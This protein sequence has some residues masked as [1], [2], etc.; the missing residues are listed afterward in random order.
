MAL[1]PMKR[2]CSIWLVAGLAALALA[3]SLRPAHAAPVETPLWQRLLHHGYSDSGPWITVHDQARVSYAQRYVSTGTTTPQLI[4]NFDPDGAPI[5]SLAACSFCYVEAAM[6]DGGMW[7]SEWRSRVGLQDF[8]RWFFRRYTAQGEQLAEVEVAPQVRLWARVLR[9]VN[10]VLEVLFLPQEQHGPVMLLRIDAEGKPEPLRTLA[11]STLWPDAW[12]EAYRR[13]EDG[14]LSLLISHSS[15]CPPIQLCNHRYFAVVWLDAQRE[16]LASY[17]STALSDTVELGRHLDEQGRLWRLWR[18]GASAINLLFVDS[19]GVPSPLRTLDARIPMASAS[20]EPF[21]GAIGGHALLRADDQLWLF[22]IKGQLS[23]HSPSP[24]G[25]ISFFRDES[26][27][28]HGYLLK[29]SVP[30]APLSLATLFD[31]RTLAPIAHF[32]RYRSPGEPNPAYRFPGSWSVLPDG[33]I[34]VGSHDSNGS[35]LAV[36]AIPGTPA[37]RPFGSGF[38]STP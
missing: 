7:V 31:P 14:R 11:F 25:P 6:S 38:E 32:D 15:I 37:Y 34:H 26:I 29:S 17:V 30:E 19:D 35:H 18:S 8:D 36:F 10:D 33:W 22:D 12:L 21:I 13:H 28:P 2:S 24:T 20:S 27:S 3:G 1:Q 5:T 23:A 4:E 9:P 16:V